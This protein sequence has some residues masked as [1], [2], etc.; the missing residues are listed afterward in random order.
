MNKRSNY[1]AY[2]KSVEM[3]ILNSL[4]FRSPISFQLEKLTEIMQA[5]SIHLQ[6]LINQKAIKALGAHKTNFFDI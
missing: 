4:L 3:P 2:S 6:T 1:S 5:Q